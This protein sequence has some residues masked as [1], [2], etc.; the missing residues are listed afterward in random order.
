[1]DVVWR[2]RTSR[3][4]DLIIFRH[5]RRAGRVVRYLFPSISL[6]LGLRPFS[7]KL[8]GALRAVHGALTGKIAQMPNFPRCD[9][10]LLNDNDTPM[11]VV[12]V[13]VGT[14]PRASL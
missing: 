4:P 9:V 5:A 14:F 12:V 7:N 3:P 10:S 11:E 1:V 2:P 13:C 6:Q 8:T